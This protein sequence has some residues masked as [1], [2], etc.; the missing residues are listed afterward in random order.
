MIVTAYVLVSI[1]TLMI[2]A[3]GL[4]YSFAPAKMA[5]GFG[6]TTVPENAD[7]FF[8]LKGVRD[9]AS[10]LIALALMLYGD[11]HA[12]GWAVLAASFIAF[13]DMATVLRHHGKKATAFGVHGLTGAVMVV[14]ALLLLLG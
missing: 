9:I 4:G 2:I 1:V 12:L 13:G 10:G 14:A 11:N 8:N 3:I 5:P 6:F 7:S